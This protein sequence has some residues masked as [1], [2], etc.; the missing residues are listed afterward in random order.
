MKFDESSSYNPLINIFFTS[1]VWSKL[2]ENLEE[3][4]KELHSLT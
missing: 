1:E 2:I 3:T 4:K